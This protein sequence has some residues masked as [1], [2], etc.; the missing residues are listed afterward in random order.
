MKALQNALLA[1]DF[2]VLT[3]AALN[4]LI[5]EGYQVFLLNFPAEYTAYDKLKA[6][7]EHRSP[8]MDALGVIRHVRETYSTKEPVYVMNAGEPGTIR[9]MFDEESG[10][11]GMDQDFPFAATA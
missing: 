3:Q 7:A 1:S 11:E 9:E 8:L 2:P 6:I 5:E 4:V 10:I